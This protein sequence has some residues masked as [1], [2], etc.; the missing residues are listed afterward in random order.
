MAEPLRRAEVEKLRIEGAS[1]YAKVRKTIL[2]DEKLA[3]AIHQ[4]P[5]E[6]AEKMRLLVILLTKAADAYI[7]LAN[8]RKDGI[9]ENAKPK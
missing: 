2:E 7:K 8:V 3:I 1:N 5:R 4:N 9:T 6:A